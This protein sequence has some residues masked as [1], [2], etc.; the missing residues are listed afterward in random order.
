MA[1]VYILWWWMDMHGNECF[2]DDE[3]ARGCLMY[4]TPPRLPRDVNK[5]ALASY[6]R[7]V[8]KRKA[9]PLCGGGNSKAPGLTMSRLYYRVRPEHI[10]QMSD[11]HT[12]GL[13]SDTC[14]EG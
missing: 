3:H 13:V 8:G 10:P 1:E 9:G 12:E 14:K 5:T 2:G 6:D 11:F 4:T 7:G